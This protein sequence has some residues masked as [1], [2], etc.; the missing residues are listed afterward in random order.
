L[1]DSELD[2]RAADEHVRGPTAAALRGETAIASARIA[3]R[4]LDEA[5]ASERFRSLA[6]RGARAQRLLWASTGTKDPSYGD[7]KYVEPLIGPRTVNTMPLQTLQAYH[8]HGRPAQRLTEHG[9]EAE[10][11]L[12]ALTDIGVNLDAATTWLLH[13]GIDKFAVAHDALLASLEKAR[14]EA[15]ART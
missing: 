15:L 9:E 14:R 7:V 10:H 4:V 11:I 5:L 13:E 3:Y 2:R 8:D 1:I 6:A 12:Q